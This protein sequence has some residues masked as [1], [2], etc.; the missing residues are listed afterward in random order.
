[1]NGKLT[2]IIEREKCST[3]EFQGFINQQLRG[4]RAALDFLFENADDDFD[5]VLAETVETK[6][7]AGLVDFFVRAQLGVAVFGGPF[8]DVRVKAFAI[9]NDRRK[10]KEVAALFQLLFEPAAQFIARLRFDG[11]DS[12]GAEFFVLRSDSPGWHSGAEEKVSSTIFAR[13]K[14]RLLRAD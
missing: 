11:R 12:F 8:G 7:F 9:A 3:A 14:D 4:F 1:M 13:G 2:V 10:Q 6:M 5:I